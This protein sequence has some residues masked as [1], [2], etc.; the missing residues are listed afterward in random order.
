MYEKS[1]RFK[2]TPVHAAAMKGHN[3][4]LSILLADNSR[5]VMHNF[6]TP[7]D[8]PPIGL[9]HSMLRYH[10]HHP[11]VYV[12]DEN[13]QTPLHYAVQFHQKE[14]VLLLLQHGADVDAK[15]R[16]GTSVLEY[17]LGDSMDI[18]R[19]L[20]EYGVNTSI[21]NFS[22]RQSI[23]LYTPQLVDL[24][25]QHKRTPPVYGTGSTQMHAATRT[26]NRNSLDIMKV[27]HKNGLDISARDLKGLT[28]LH[29]AIGLRDTNKV[30]FLLDNWADLDSIDPRVPTPEDHATNLLAYPIRDMIRDEQVRRCGIVEA[31]MMAQHQR[32]G[33]NSGIHKMDP[34]MVKHLIKS[35]SRGM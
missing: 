32:L 2:C 34:N 27:F 28:P 31:I 9:S 17:A 5:E 11:A 18:I 6:H 25:M 30:R 16:G 33:Q 12:T 1:S 14:A 20:L 3:E 23:W 29:Y 15:D 4:I 7:H 24:M 19:I 8:K 13:E 26:L 21:F 10:T 22:I 35:L